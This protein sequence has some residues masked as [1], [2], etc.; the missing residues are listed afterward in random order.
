VGIISSF[1]QYYTIIYFLYD[2]YIL[3]PSSSFKIYNMRV[4]L[5]AL[6]ALVFGLPIYGQEPSATLNLEST[7]EGFLPPRM[8]SGDR[9]AIITPSDGMIIFNTSSGFINYYDVFSG[10]L[11]LQPQETFPSPEDI[12]I[13]YFL[14]LPN[15]VQILLD[16]GE[17]PAN[18][19]ANGAVVA[20]FYGLYYQGG[21]IFYV[22]ASD[23]SGFVSATEDQSMGADWGCSGTNLPGAEGLNLGDGEQNTLDILANC[24]DPD[25]AAEIC[26]LLDLNGYDDW[27]LPS[28]G[29]LQ[30]M[31]LRIGQAADNIGGFVNDWYYSSSE[32][33]TNSVYAQLFTDGF[34]ANNRGKGESDPIRAIRAFP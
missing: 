16:A 32:T 18:L 22:D 13:P 15:G 3:Y 4:L 12:V 5:I 1:C 10:W 29:E 30:T 2:S 11:V 27:F 26:S 28:I 14:S 6:C 8:S 9:D 23:G 24:A 34:V 20:D 17:T 33:N 25:I 31:R 21:I 7:T 19:L